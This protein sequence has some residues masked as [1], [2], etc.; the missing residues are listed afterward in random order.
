MSGRAYYTLH[1]QRGPVPQFQL[2]T[3]R[4]YSAFSNLK[5]QYAHRGYTLIKQVEYCE[6]GQFRYGVYWEVLLGTC[7]R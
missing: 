1:M 7:G 4:D 2:R 6:Y 5:A 3:G